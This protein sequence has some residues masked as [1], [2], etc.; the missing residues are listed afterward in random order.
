MAWDRRHLSS[1]GG[2]EAVDI[3]AQKVLEMTGVG[4]A[5]DS[6]QLTQFQPPKTM[7]REHR[8]LAADAPSKGGEPGVEQRAPERCLPAASLA[9]QDKTGV[10]LTARLKSTTHSADQGFDQHPVVDR[11]W[12]GKVSGAEKL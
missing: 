12:S 1:V 7:D 4:L 11:L 10:V 2:T 5:S 8:V 6:I 3:G 9:L